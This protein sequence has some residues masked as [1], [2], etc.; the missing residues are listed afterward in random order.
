MM[1][2][3]L[4]ETTERI[5]ARSQATRERYVAQMREAG[6]QGP[7]RDRLSCSNLA[8]GIAAQADAEKKILAVTRSSNLAIVS[9]YNE[10][11]SAHQPYERFPAL[12]K[13]AAMEAGAVAQ[14]AGGVPAMCDG[15]TQGRAG[16]ELSLFSREVIATATAIALSHDLFDGV[17]CLGICDKIVPGMLIGALRFGHLPCIFVPAG[18]MRTGYSNAEKARVR[19]LYAEGKASREELLEAECAAY[20]GP[21]TCTF[22]GT[23]NTNQVLMEVMGLHLPG[24]TFLNPDD[25]GRDLY[26]RLA[27]QRLVEIGAH[28]EA[29]TP[30]FEIIDER[31]VVNG[32]V[33]LLASGGSTNHTIHL[34]AMALAAGIVINWDDFAA[35]SAVV[36]LL[37][38]VYPNGSAD[39]NAFRRAGGIAWLVRELLGAGLLHEDVRTV[40]G[41]GLR[42]YQEES[43]VRDATVVYQPLP[44][45]SRDPDVLRPATQP[46]RPDSGLALLQGNLGRAILKTSALPPDRERISAPARV[47]DSQQALADAFHADELAC[48]FVAVLP[49]Q[50]P[51]ANGMPELHQLTP[52]LGSLQ[53]AGHRVAIVTDGR[54][55]GASGKV[56]AAIHVWPEA[57]QGGLLGRVR[58][59]DPILIDAAAGVL[60]VQVDDAE[61]ARRSP[62][63]GSKRTTG[64]GRELFAGMRARVSSAESGALALFSGDGD[65]LL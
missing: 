62:W 8:H 59:G 30:L 4:R 6:R 1:H 43:C 48:D 32:I 17:L 65:S 40:A 50:G 42:R 12:I 22:Y 56:P 18:P 3:V 27:T 11:L 39:V 2:S 60:S 15:V 7:V 47:F 26:T 46:F 34:V 5:V 21:G 24:G 37:A 23:A 54:M 41:D 61:L 9:A 35:L 52:L 64:V 25:P 29:P 16:M 58:D 63:A 20:H 10:M 53:D 31:A 38:R 19:Q 55:S 14:F 36:P 49:G 28:G 51:A 57:A 13:Q 33:A 45:Q 44:E